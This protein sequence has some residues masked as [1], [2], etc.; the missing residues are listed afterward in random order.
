ME[1]QDGQIAKLLLER[2]HTK[3][4]PRNHVKAI[5]LTNGK[6]VEMRRDTPPTQEKELTV[7]ACEDLEKEK[8]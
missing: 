7:E 4:N 2:S 8:D 5:T 1:N 3:A 6:Q